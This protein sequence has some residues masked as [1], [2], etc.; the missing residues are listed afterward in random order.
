[1]DGGTIGE[2]G[3][4]EGDAAQGFH[5][6]I[7]DGREHQAHLVAGHGLAGGAVGEQFELLADAVLGLAPG[8][9]RSS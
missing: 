8:A 2:L 6:D 7:G 4:F 1:M 5:Q 3:V 9:Y